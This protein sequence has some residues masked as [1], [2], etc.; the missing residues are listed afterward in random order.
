MQDA[1]RRGGGMIG[2]AAGGAIGRGIWVEPVKALAST[3]PILL[4]PLKITNA[5]WENNPWLVGNR[6]GARLR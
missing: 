1:A 4:N 6:Y 2:T 3:T 5:K